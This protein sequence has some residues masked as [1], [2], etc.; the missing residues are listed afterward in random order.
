MI[1]AWGHALRMRRTM[2]FMTLMISGAVG[3]L[4]ARSTLV[5]YLPERP[6]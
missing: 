1:R 3:V 5:M 6:S 4:P 2:R